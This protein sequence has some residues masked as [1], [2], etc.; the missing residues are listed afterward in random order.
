MEYAESGMLFVLA[1]VEDVEMTRSIHLL[2]FPTFF[3]PRTITI[4]L[5]YGA[6]TTNIIHIK[7]Q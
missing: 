7:K 4:T 3:P 6:N 2:L 5:F 1:V